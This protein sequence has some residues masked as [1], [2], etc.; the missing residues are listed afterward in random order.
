MTFDGT[1]KLDMSKETLLLEKRVA[2]ES[3]A[4][5]AG[6]PTNLT[7]LCRPLA[8]IRGNDGGTGF[9]QSFRYLGQSRSDP[10][11]RVPSGLVRKNPGPIPNSVAAAA[12][13]VAEQ[14]MPAADRT[15][16]ARRMTP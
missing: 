7:A 15:P 2:T 4:T 16:M 1:L 10:A 3:A 11:F 12:N 14:P 13:V 9:H 6:K 8:R 5:P